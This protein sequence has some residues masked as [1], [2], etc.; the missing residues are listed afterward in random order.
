MADKK[1]K[2]KEFPIKYFDNCVKIVFSKLIAKEIDVRLEIIEGLSE[3]S[4]N[5]EINRINQCT[6]SNLTWF[7]GYNGNFDV[8]KIYGKK[9]VVSGLRNGCASATRGIYIQNV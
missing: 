8:K 7:I 9:I 2:R 5:K 1:K 6:G 4:D 3:I